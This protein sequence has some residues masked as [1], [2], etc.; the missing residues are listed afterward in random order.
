MPPL[1]ATCCCLLGPARLEANPRFACFAVSVRPHGVVQS[2]PSFPL[3]VV[4]QFF[5]EVF[6]L[7]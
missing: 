1:S 2:P 3:A 5:F 6:F 7:S 4:E